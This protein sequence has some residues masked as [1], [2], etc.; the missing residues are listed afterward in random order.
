[1]GSIL[2]LNWASTEQLKKNSDDGDDKN[3][4]DGRSWRWW[5]INMM[6]MDGHDHDDDDDDG[7]DDDD[8]DEDDDDDDDINSSGVSAEAWVITKKNAMSFRPPWFTLGDGSFLGRHK[9]FC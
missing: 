1:M 4:V 6:L 3:D 5:K 8:E 7:D 2:I 9:L